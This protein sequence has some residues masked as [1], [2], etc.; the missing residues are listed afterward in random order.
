MTSI[1][2]IASSTLSNNNNILVP[3]ASDKTPI[4]WDGN[5]ANILGIVERMRSEVTLKTS[6]S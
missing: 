4:K 5:D 2:D 1:D 6:E 3:V